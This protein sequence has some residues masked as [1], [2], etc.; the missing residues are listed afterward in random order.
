MDVINTAVRQFFA[1]IGAFWL[2]HPGRVLPIIATDEQRALAAQALCLR[3]IAPDNRRAYFVF[4]ERFTTSSS[5]FYGLAEAIAEQYERLRVA[6]ANDGV[7][8]PPFAGEP[9]TLP[10]GAVE[11]AA[12]AMERA[13]QLLEDRLDGI[14]VALVP[15][16][17]ALPKAWREGGRA[18]AAR[19][20]SPRV[21]L[22]VLAPLGGSL[23]EIGGEGVRFQF[24]ADE[25]LDYCAEALDV[26]RSRR[27]RRDDL[28]VALA[29]IERTTERLHDV[30][31]PLL[32]RLPVTRPDAPMGEEPGS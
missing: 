31:D 20:W 29:Q 24:D 23:D 32:E 1:D 5:Y 8:L 10:S 21:R 7:E 27:R 12:H 26:P 22:A 11:Y 18:L 6:L 9:S 16:H 14:V 30:E 15:E 3:E 19:R 28:V 13:A 2:A 25:V 17:I 4:H